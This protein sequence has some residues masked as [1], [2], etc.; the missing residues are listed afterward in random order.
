M[1]RKED[2][3]FGR[4]QGDR[5]VYISKDG[6]THT[7]RTVSSSNSR[8]LSEEVKQKI[9]EANR[10]DK[11]HRAARIEGAI[12]LGESLDAT[13]V[14]MTGFPPGVD[15]D[16]AVYR[17]NQD[18]SYFMVA[19]KRDEVASTNGPEDV[20]HRAKRRYRVPLD[21]IGEYAIVRFNLK[22]H[23]EEGGL[24]YT[25]EGYIERKPYNPKT[26]PP[27]AAP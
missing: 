8:R 5:V 21:F 2:P 23:I 11:M 26:D 1:A 10:Q 14:A 4:I 9:A 7:K 16:P 3:L 27:I 15:A 25:P 17:S 20:Q 19:G 24:F 12:E 18:N 22:K 6:K 13:L